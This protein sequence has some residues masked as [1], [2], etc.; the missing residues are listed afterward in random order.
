MRGLYSR[1]TVFLRA[2]VFVLMTLVVFALLVAGW[3]ALI[4]GTGGSITECDR[5]D[6]GALGEFSFNTSPLVA[7]VFLHRRRDV[8][9]RGSAHRAPLKVLAPP[10]RVAVV[11]S[12]SATT[13]RRS[14]MLTRPP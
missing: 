1:A 11:I 7:L 2:V 10:A 14:S 9:A 12:T 13:H 3:F 4:L 5:G 6:C 8:L